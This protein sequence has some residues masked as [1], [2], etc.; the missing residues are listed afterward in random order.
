[1]VPWYK[2]GIEVPHSLRHALFLDRK[3]RNH[4]WREAI[5]IELRQINHYKTFQVIGGDVDFSTYTRM[6]Y[7]FVFNV[8]F[9]LRHKA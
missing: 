9:N 5:K 1:M 7:H 8:K 3:N 6:P 2:F 4:L